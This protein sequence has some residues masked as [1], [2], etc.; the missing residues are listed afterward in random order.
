MMAHNQRD[1]L[2]RLITILLGTAATAKKGKNTASATFKIVSAARNL[3][4]P[5]IPYVVVETFHFEI[6]FQAKKTSK[7]DVG[8]VQKRK[9]RE[10]VNKA[11]RQRQEGFYR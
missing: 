10:I 6:H 11:T 4:V 9:T 8:L 7:S 3:A 1:G 2:V 5:R